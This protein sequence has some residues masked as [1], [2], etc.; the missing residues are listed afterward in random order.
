M[1]QWLLCSI[2]S[3]HKAW[4]LLSADVRAAFLKGDPYVSR[5]LFIQQ[6]NPR[7]GPSIPLPAG[8]LAKV[9]KGVFGLA[10]APREWYLRLHREVS[11]EGWERSNLDLALWLRYGPREPPVEV[12]SVEV[13]PQLHKELC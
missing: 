10:D 5:T 13:M 9:V 2:S 7:E 11:A 1:A 12:N 4:R 6:T 8:T 3:H